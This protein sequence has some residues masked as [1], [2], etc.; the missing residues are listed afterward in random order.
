MILPNLKAYD[1]MILQEYL[2]GQ[3][4]N[5]GNGNASG[6]AAGPTTDTDVEMVIAAIVKALIALE[7]D[8][9]LLMAMGGMTN[10]N[11]GSGGVDVREK[12]RGKIGGLLG[13]RVFQLGR[14]ALAYA[15]LEDG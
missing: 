5:I 10:G 2:G 7:E 3:R 12:L 13:D 11:S 15:V 14:Y 4:S 1:E 6:T 8:N 9:R